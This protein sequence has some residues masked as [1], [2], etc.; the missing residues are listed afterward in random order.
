MSEFKD[1][2]INMFDVAHAVPVLEVSF[3]DYIKNNAEAIN[4]LYGD[5]YVSAT[6]HTPYLAAI[7]LDGLTAFPKNDKG[8]VE[9]QELMVFFDEHANIFM[10]NAKT[11]GAFI[12]ASD[13]YGE[14]R[15]LPV[16]ISKQ[17]QVTVNTQTSLVMW[18]VDE[19]YWDNEMYDRVDFLI[20]LYSDETV[21][22]N[23]YHGVGLPK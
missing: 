5:D 12:P 18:L 20:R 17:N 1:T 8:E 4:G 7:K 2:A 6:M 19:A 15:F 23:A 3:A 21:Q 11:A 13:W 14:E 10:P 9:E 22:Y 16:P